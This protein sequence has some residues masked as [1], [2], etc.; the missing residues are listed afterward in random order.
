MNLTRRTMLRGIGG[1]VICL[2][3]L[4]CL[5]EVTDENPGASE[6]RRYVHAQWSQSPRL[7]AERSRQRL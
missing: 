1:A 6:I 7:G 3:A 2:P 5:G 4:E